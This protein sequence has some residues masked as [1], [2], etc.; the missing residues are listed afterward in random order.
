M[1]KEI[2]KKELEADNLR[3]EIEVMKRTILL[4]KQSEEASKRNMEEF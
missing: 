1:S 2:A 3:G 4:S